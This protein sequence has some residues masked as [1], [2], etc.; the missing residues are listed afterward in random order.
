MDGPRSPRE[1]YFLHRITTSGETTSRYLFHEAENAASLNCEIYD[2]LK[3][4][5]AVNCF[6]KTIH[7]RCLAGFLICL[8]F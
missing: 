8:R 7:R 1:S 2:L 5:I 6:R 4:I 3:I